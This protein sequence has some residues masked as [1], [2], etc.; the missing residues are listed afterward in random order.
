MKTLRKLL[1]LL[2][3]LTLCF[4]LT[5]IAFAD[6]NETPAEDPT[7]TTENPAEATGNPVKVADHTFTAYQ[8]FKGTQGVDA[9][10]N[11]IKELGN[12]TWGDGIDSTAFLAAL[13][14]DKTIGDKFTA[15]MTAAEVAKVLA[16]FDAA[17]AKIVAKLAAT[18]VTG[19]GTTIADGGRLS[20]PGYYIIVDTTEDLGEYDAYNLS[21]LQV[22]NPVTIASK[23]DYPSSEKKVKDDEA[24]STW[25]DT[26]DY[27][28]GDDVPFQITGT[29]PNAYDDYET[30]KYIIHDVMSDG[31]TLN[32]SGVKVSVDG[33]EITAGYTL[34]TA[35]TDGCTFEITFA[36]AKAVTAIK[37]G[38]KITV[39][40]TAKLNDKAV[41][42]S[43]GNSNTSY[44][45][46]S[47]KPNGEATGK[48]PKDIVTV[49][50][51]K[52]VVNKIDDKKNALVGAGFTLYILEDGEY[53]ACGEELKGDQLT[54]FTWERIDEGQYKLSETTTPAGFNTAEDI[55]F[56]VTAV[57]KD[58]DTPA[59][60]SLT[61]TETDKDGKAVE[62]KEGE[63]AAFTATMT[64]GTIETSVVNETGTLLPS[65]GGIGTTLFYA[66]GGL[67]VLAAGVVIVVRR[68]SEEE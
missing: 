43:A 8:I 15:E 31:L 34:S 52:L 30:Y 60:E 48:T 66:V 45:E 40:Y 24:G 3:V 59:L 22:T 50:T 65:T 58:G 35:C 41:V 26:A 5:L 7:E 55:Y 53:T 11:T 9:E 17:Q 38:S 64:T 42:G 39:D 6:E 21:L 16:A 51:Y 2:L 1:S 23:N 20:V 29:I 33:T 4:S 63:E 37:A 57:T 68:K 10:G 49:F 28:V 36:D 13:I 62:K 67:L 25:S 12:I 56:T 46:Y 47:N 19:E 44:L 61:V 32:E 27:A 54:T 14:A 18:N